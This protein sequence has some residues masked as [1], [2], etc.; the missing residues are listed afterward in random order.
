MIT[1]VIILIEAKVS[2]ARYLM[3]VE[4]ETVEGGAIGWLGESWFCQPCVL[5]TGL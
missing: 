3:G 4:V 2:T 5:A 1:C